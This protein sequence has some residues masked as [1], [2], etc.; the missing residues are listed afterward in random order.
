MKTLLRIKYLTQA[1][2]ALFR[3]IK[4]PNDLDKVIRIA[5]KIA[6]AEDL[7][8][9][10]EILSR[11]SEHAAH[12]LKTFP[13]IELNTLFQSKNELPSGSLGL[14]FIDFLNERGLDPADLPNLPVTSRADFVKAH[15]FE[16]HDLWHVLT[17]FETDPAGELGLQAFYHAQIPAPLSPILLGA[18]F[19]NTSFFAAHE[20]NQRMQEIIRGWQLGKAAAP[21]FGIDWK[22][23]WHRPLTEVQSQFGLNQIP[24][25]THTVSKPLL[26]LTAD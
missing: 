24:A 4:N 22:K 3:L 15:L 13:R 18:G 8:K 1:G 6:K 23:Y 9:T 16:T 21:L 12:S 19:L 11:Q 17:G 7:E 20:K 25:I 5:D 14:A 2:L 10:A 26:V